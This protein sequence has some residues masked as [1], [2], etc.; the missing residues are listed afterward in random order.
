M[1]HSLKIIHGDIKPENIMWSPTFKK[2]VL[3][4]FGLSLFLSEKPGFKTLTNYFGTYQFSSPEMKKILSTKTAMY[5]D[6]YY[7]D[8]FAL[9]KSISK[10]SITQ[11]NPIIILEYEKYNNEADKFGIYAVNIKLMNL[12][13]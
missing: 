12:V 6:L 2:N 7:N 8:L 5:V 1:L 10:I 11:S 4:D 9:K 13:F 3:I